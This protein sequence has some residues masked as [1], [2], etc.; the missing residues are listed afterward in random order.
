LSLLC[1]PEDEP[2]PETQEMQIY[3]LPGHKEIM[4]KRNEA[5]TA[6]SN[7][8]QSKVFEYLRIF[9]SKKEQEEKWADKWKNSVD[10]LK[11]KY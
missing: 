7:L 9:E 8:Y 4:V 2:K 5:L 10:L 11:S 3:K 6:F 1:L